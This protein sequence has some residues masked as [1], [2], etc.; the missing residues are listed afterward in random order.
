MCRIRGAQVRMDL[1]LWYNES[2]GRGLPPS[3]PTEK[4]TLMKRSALL[5]GLLAGAL[6]LTLAACGPR[7]T[8]VPSPSPSE[9][10]S[11]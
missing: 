9:P 1:Q 6:F 5:S 2:T 10:S 8:P 7:E 3:T 4:E 11:A